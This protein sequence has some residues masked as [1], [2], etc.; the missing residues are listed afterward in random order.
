[1]IANSWSRR[2]NWTRACLGLVDMLATLGD[3]VQHPLPPFRIGPP[4]VASAAVDAAV[5]VVVILAEVVD[6]EEAVVAVVA[7]VEVVVVTTSA[8]GVPTATP[9]AVK[10]GENV[11]RAPSR[12]K[13]GT[14]ID[15]GL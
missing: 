11:P 10:C 8:A 5:A 4:R 6:A 12:P 15:L 9:T 2:G 3:G 1:M 14:V 13:T 7:A